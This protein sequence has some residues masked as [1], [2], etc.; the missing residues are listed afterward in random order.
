MTEDPSFRP[1]AGAPRDRFVSS[2]DPEDRFTRSDE[3]IHLGE[4]V[5][6]YKA[7]DRQSGLE[8]TWHEVFLLPHTNHDEIDA[9]LA[10]IHRRFGSLKFAG[11]GAVLH[12]WRSPDYS[13]FI[14][15]TESIS[16]CSLF[17]SI[18]REDRKSVV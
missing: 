15:I 14:Y 17:S 8:V 16:T 6:R 2:I 18:S 11:L 1:S 7:Y 4:G 10:D 5:V 9:I 13:R 12:A 3:W